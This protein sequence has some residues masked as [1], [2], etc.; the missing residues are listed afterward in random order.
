ML[1]FDFLP[2]SL[3]R[4]VSILLGFGD[5]CSLVKVGCLVI[6]VRGVEEFD[7][8]ISFDCVNCV[9]EVFI[10]DGYTMCTCVIHFSDCCHF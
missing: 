8:I 9:S 6:Y 2:E 3:I 5:L 7:V 1:R 4:G 10:I